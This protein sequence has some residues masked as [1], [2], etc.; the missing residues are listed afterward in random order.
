MAKKK[1]GRVVKMLSP[2]NYIKQKAR[3]LVIH[4]C[5]VNK[6]WQQGGL[7]SVIVVR[8]HSNGNFTLGFYLVDLLC[9]GLKDTDYYFNILPSKYSEFIEDEK[10]LMDL[11]SIDYILA[12]N[13]VFSGIEYADDYE[14]K[15]HKDF[16]ITKHILEED[17]YDIELIDI[18]CGGEAYEP[19]L[20]LGIEEDNAKEKQL[21]AH[22]ERVAGSGNYTLIRAEEEDG[23][24]EIAPFSEYDNWSEGK[25]LK[26]IAVLIEDDDKIAKNFLQINVLIDV[27]ITK[28]GNRD[29]AVSCFDNLVEQFS[30]VEYVDDEPLEF[31][32]KLPVLSDKIEAYRE[33]YIE[34][35]NLIGAKNRNVLSKIKALKK[36]YPENAASCFLELF[37]HYDSNS[38]KTDVL[39][40][41]YYH[42][43]SDFHLIDMLWKA[44]KYGNGTHNTANVDFQNA[45]NTY[46]LGRTK[47]SE[48]E[49]FFFCLMLTT[50]AIDSKNI[51][52]LVAVQL[53]IETL[54]FEEELN[55]MLMT[56]IFSGKLIFTCNIGRE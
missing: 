54:E 17:T 1:K 55:N 39:L 19:V 34:I 50:N 53:F 24:D 32:E 13:I 52:E 31:F 44:A 25:L 46:F 21:I 29:K 9:Q 47:L 7:A 38:K 15:P 22:L 23:F 26:K 35:I 10:Q 20:V 30:D 33:E 51:E 2:E 36:K 41:K 14:F 6:E 27:L 37:Y 56:V 45:F 43:Y 48:S 49:L 18:D 3:S 40:D 4:E 8:K 5:W 28:R 42:L 11:E 12:H 16:S